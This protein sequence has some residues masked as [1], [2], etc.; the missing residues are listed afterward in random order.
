M[1]ESFN[2][3]KESLPYLLQGGVITLV[4]VVGAMSLGLVLGLCMAVGQVYGHP[5]LKRVIGVYIWFFQGKFFRYHHAGKGNTGGKP[6]VFAISSGQN[7]YIKIN[8]RQGHGFFLRKKDKKKADKNFTALEFGL[9]VTLKTQGEKKN[10]HELQGTY[11]FNSLIFF[12]K[13][14]NFFYQT[15]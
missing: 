9:A 1:I 5:F 3:I 8:N 10:L 14:T 4:I 15:H 12:I 11:Y 13:L 6:A 2:A 7:F